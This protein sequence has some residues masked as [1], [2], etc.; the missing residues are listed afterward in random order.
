MLASG[1]LPS[2]WKNGFQPLDVLEAGVG[3]MP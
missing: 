3:S 2:D 1:L